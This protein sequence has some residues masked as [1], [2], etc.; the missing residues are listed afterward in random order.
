MGD[1]V[2]SG[3]WDIFLA[4]LTFTNLL[5]LLLYLRLLLDCLMSRFSKRVKRSGTPL[6]SCFLGSLGGGASYLIGLFLIFE[7]SRGFRE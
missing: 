4:V 7:G 1:R 6:F 2:A 5:L 3:L